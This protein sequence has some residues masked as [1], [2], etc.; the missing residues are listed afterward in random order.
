MTNAD[1][2]KIAFAQLRREGLIARQNFLCCSGCALSQIG[3]DFAKPRNAI[4]AGFVFY[5]RQDTERLRPKQRY[6]KPSET[7]HLRFG[8]RP[9]A[10]LEDQE[11]VI[12]G[13]AIVDALA[14]VGLEAKWNGDPRVTIEV[15]LPGGIDALPEPVIPAGATPV[16]IP[17]GTH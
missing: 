16:M 17:S 1:L 13:R 3:A 9:G 2:L 10:I 7:L 8:A 4:K 5:H 15:L 14:D 12:V 11:T 6:V